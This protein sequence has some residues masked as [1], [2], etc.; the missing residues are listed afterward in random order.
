M[1]RR[2]H[3]L[4]QCAVHIRR[5]VVVVGCAVGASVSPRDSNLLRTR[6][7]RTELSLSSR[8]GSRFPM[9][10]ELSWKPPKISARKPRFSVRSCGSSNVLGKETIILLRYWCYTRLRAEGELRRARKKFWKI[11]VF[12]RSIRKK[13]SPLK[14]WGKSLS[15]SRA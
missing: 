6:G 12:R 7:R 8:E 10:Q 4:V 15:D 1:I 13:S 14:T 5:I 9:W 2:G 11:R 3:T